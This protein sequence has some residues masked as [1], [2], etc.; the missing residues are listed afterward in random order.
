[1][2]CSSTS[3]A[4][5]GA[6]HSLDNQESSNITITIRLIKSFAYRNIKLMILKDIQSEQLTGHDLLN[7]IKDKIEKESAYLP[8]RNR[9]YDTLKMYHHAHSF[10]ANNLVINFQ[11]D[12]KLVLHLDKTLKE[13][14]VDNEA[15]ISCFIWKEYLEFKHNP[16]IKW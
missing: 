3:D 12:D 4:S 6:T 1:M 5:S 11:D 13:N 9:P 7:L 2:S 10:K 16:E 8:H 15:E 14:G